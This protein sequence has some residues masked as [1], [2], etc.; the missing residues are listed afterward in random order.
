MRKLLYGFLALLMLV[1][2]CSEKPPVVSVPADAPVMVSSDP[3]DGTTGLAG[4]KLT[5][6]LT[7]DQNIKCPSDQQK[8]VRLEGGGSIDKVNAYNTVLTVEISGLDQNSGKEY[9]VVVPE[10]AV[11]GFRENQEPAAEVRIR[12][13]MKYVEPYVPSTLDPVKTLVN[14][15][16][17]QQA[18]NVYGFLLEQSGKKT[19][20]GVQS[21]HSNTNDYVDAVY[22]ATG[23]HPALAGYDFIFLQYSPTPEG[24]SWVRDYND[25]SAPK[26][27]WAAN[28]LV[29]YMWHWN[30]PDSEAAWKNAT[31]NYNFD[32]YNFYSDKTSFDIK[33]ALKEGT[34][35]NRFIMND[36]AEV[37]G[38]LKL[39]QAE[40]IPVIWRPLHEAAGNYDL[41][42]PN[43]AWFW[44]GRGGAEPCKQ[45]WRLLYDQLV[46]VHGL[47]NLIWVWTVDVAK[48]AE[49]QYLDWYP[50]DE[51]V[52]I[53]GVDIYAAD[54]EAKTRQYQALVD[55]TKGKKLVTVSECGNI[56]D[57]TKCMEA[58]NRWSW[59]MVWPT[60]DENG[61]ILLNTSDQNFKLNTLDYWKKVMGN[62]YV[63]TREAMPSLK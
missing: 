43:G 41:Y 24:W 19:L 9:T 39:L 32:G 17:S 11:L 63:I 27:Q 22:K 25:I 5:M 56:P 55:L 20:S 57:P 60:S 50:G 7:Y 42:G 62:K 1:A 10:G 14:P 33:E 13:T 8:N 23:K 3:A 26:A 36:I 47:N 61:N 18:K 40:N 37:A 58:G 49:D 12:F 16:A 46:N 38:Y 59:F 51:Y 29:N 35:Q 48:G 21:S 31:D 53:V 44:W 34:W 30:V 28:G 52:D 15:N 4:D 45:L 2:G 6:K 54:T